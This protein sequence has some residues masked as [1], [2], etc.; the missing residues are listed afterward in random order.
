LDSYLEGVDPTVANDGLSTTNIAVSPSGMISVQFNSA[1]DGTTPERYYDVWDEDGSFSN[2]VSW[3]RIISNLPPAG[4]TTT[5]NDDASQ[6]TQRFYRVTIAGYT[7]DVVTPEI[8][9]LQAQVL[10]NGNNYVSMSTLPGT[11]TLLGVLGTNQLTQGS[12][13]GTAADVEIWDQ[14]DQA[15]DP[16]QVYYLG[17]GATGWLQDQTLAPANNTVLDANK[18]IVITVR[19]NITLRLVGFVPTTSQVQTVASNGY[20]VASATFPM[21]TSLNASNQPP[22]GDASGL[23]ASGFTGGSSKI[24]SDNLL[25]Y[26]PTTGA[27][28][29]AIWYDNVNH[30]WRNSN[31]S[32]T[33]NPLQPGQA[34]LIQ[35]K[36]RANN[37]T[38]TNAVPYNVPLQGP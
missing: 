35:L 25:L 32:I 12:F 27:F 21:P 28:D 1:Q 7:S 26:D 2:G 10:V 5:F 23:I 14:G 3:S 4:P 19:S 17:T 34:F 15:F 33:T 30:V 22:Y 38:W 6:A 31:A 36:A 37:L 24:H 8:V 18:G 16:A 29:I 13:D 9:G 20:T 11:S